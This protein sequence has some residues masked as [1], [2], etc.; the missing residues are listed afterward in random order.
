MRFLSVVIVAA[1]LCGSLYAAE[2]E[3]LVNVKSEILSKNVFRGQLRN[4]DPVAAT[5]I[6]FEKG[7]FG[8]EVKGV[9]DL[10]DFN[11]NSGEVSELGLDLY[12]KS[13]IYANPAGKI[14]NEITTFG[15]FEL[16]TYPQSEDNFPT[17]STVEAYVGLDTMS[18]KLGSIHTKTTAHYD[19]DK[20]NGW[21]IDSAIYRP[22]DIK[23]ATF[24]LGKQEF[25]TTATPE[26]GM[27]WGS[28]NYNKYY[29]DSEGSA[30]TDWNAALKVICE[31]KNFQFGPSIT[32]TDLVGHDIQ[33][34][35][36]DSSNWIYGF[37]AGVKF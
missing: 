32:Y 20:A 37:M 30:T 4:E 35:Q 8:L 33:A 31:S 7:I 27:G 6:G 19:L 10:T 17:K 11:G 15:G 2:G 12:V 22:I 36:E 1:V 16:F 29:W 13:M 24:K 5:S 14:V 3:A 9:N 26:I 34:A 23:K 25:K 21:Y 18:K 28:Q